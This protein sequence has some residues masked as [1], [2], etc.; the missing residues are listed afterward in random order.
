MIDQN[1][2]TTFTEY[3]ESGRG[4]LILVLGILSII[5]LGP[6]VGI[7]A[8]I[9]GN[10][11]LKKIKNGLISIKEKGL[12]KAGMILGIIGTF[13]FL[14]VFSISVLIGINLYNAE[15]ALANR[16]AVISELFNL[17]AIAH[18]YY[19][20][21]VAVGGGGKSFLGFKIPAHLR[22]TENGKY[23]IE[24]IESQSLFIIGIGIEKGNDGS[25]PIKVVVK[26]L[27]DRIEHNELN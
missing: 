5:L 8:W 12:T 19:H 16:D 13:L 23:S 6:F 24:N 22:K 2:K 20:K 7:P 25:S 3:Q 1:S 11:D 14:I 17:G 4:T 21:S 10:K 9:M 27:S 18:Q 26:V 15:S